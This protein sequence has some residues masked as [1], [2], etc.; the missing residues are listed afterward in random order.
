M[1]TVRCLLWRVYSSPESDAVSPVE[2]GD[3][4]NIFF[5]IQWEK[6]K[7]LSFG[8]KKHCKGNEFDAQEKIPPRG[9][10]LFAIL[11]W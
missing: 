2:L 11:C 3:S 7:Q 5:F 9:T 1:D 10:K 6:G 8:R 4:I